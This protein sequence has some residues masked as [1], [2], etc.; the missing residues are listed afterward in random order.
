MKTQK[1]Y[2]YAFIFFLFISCN[3]ENDNKALQN[4]NREFI[5]SIINDNQF[6]CNNKQYADYIIKN[7]VI[8][9]CFYNGNSGGC[10]N[11]SLELDILKINI[12]SI[13]KSTNY[14]NQKSIDLKNATVRFRK[15]IND[16]L[17]RDYYL[18]SGKNS[19][20]TID[21]IT[22][23]NYI[24]GQFSGK[25]YTYEYNRQCEAILDDNNYPL[26]SLYS[27]G[28]IFFFKVIKK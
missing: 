8:A 1:S 6:I 15:Q 3:K 4:T 23:D 19:T 16:S 5:K 28:G 21:F 27:T 25:F 9:S 10:G 2:V 12:D 14:F 26:D 17:F 22:P 24:M 7:H 18:Y 13:I 20:I 11:N